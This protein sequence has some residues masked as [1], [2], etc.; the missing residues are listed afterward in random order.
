MK[1]LICGEGPNDIGSIDRWS[2]RKESQVIQEGWLQPLLKKILDV[3]V[4]FVVVPRNRLVSLPGRLTRKVELSGHGVKAFT[5]KQ[6]AIADGCD[7]V[8]FMVDADTR[9]KAEWE[10]KKR[11]I[12]GGFTAIPHDIRCVACVPM[13]ASESWLLTDANAWA[14]MGL[15]NPH[16]LPKAPEEI[17]GKRAD[18]LA[19]HPHQVFARLCKEAGIGDNTPNRA[20]LME[21]TQSSSIAARCPVSFGAFVKELLPSA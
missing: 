13:S 11:D 15:K 1:I 17:W 3:D 4:E 9:A 14:S 21:L 7:V 19:N 16:A 12:H 20:Q 5:A 2:I 18:P 10:K 6:R 8:V